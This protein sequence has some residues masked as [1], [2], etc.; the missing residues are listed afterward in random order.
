MSILKAYYLQTGHF[1]YN[2]SCLFYSYLPSCSLCGA[3][4]HQFLK[5]AFLGKKSF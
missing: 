5:T 4:C 3:G 1:C 2:M